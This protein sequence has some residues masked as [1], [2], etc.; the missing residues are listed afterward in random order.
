MQLLYG[1]SIM[2]TPKLEFP[3]LPGIVSSGRADIPS[4]VYSCIS[5]SFPSSTQFL[6]PSS[7]HQRRVLENE[8]M[9]IDL[10]SPLDFGLFGLASRV[11]EI[12]QRSLVGIRGG[13]YSYWFLA[14]FISQCRSGIHYLQKPQRSRQLQVHHILLCVFNP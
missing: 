1:G 6:V 3:S 14:R 2:H 11:C 13:G 12:R 9:K 7:A 10:L 4:A 5:S 8:F